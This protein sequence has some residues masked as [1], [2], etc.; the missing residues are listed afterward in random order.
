MQLGDGTVILIRSS[1]RAGCSN[2]LHHLDLCP[3]T[4]LC[5]YFSRCVLFSPYKQNSFLSSLPYLGSWLFSVLSGVVAD[6]LLEKELLSTTTV[7]KSFTVIGMSIAR[8][9]HTYL[10][11]FFII[12]FIDKHTH[13]YCIALILLKVLKVEK[14]NQMKNIIFGPLFIEENDPILHICE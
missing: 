6:I 5:L 3:S 10:L 9:I 2:V 12:T 13:L 14:E 4:L 11:N 7:R 8:T 1:H